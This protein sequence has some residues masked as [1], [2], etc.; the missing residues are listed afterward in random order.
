MDNR[1]SCYTITMRKNI[2]YDINL[3]D[4]MLRDGK[5]LREIASYYGVFH[6]SLNSWLKNKGYKI[7]KTIDPKTMKTG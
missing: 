6:N 3:I 1:G 4:K 7:I 2:D 5:S